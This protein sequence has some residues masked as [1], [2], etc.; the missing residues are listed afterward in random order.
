MRQKARYLVRNARLSL[1]G[2]PRHSPSHARVN[3]HKP[4]LYIPVS[5]HPLVADKRRLKRPRSTPQVVGKAYRCDTRRR[6]EML[7]LPSVGVCE[8]RN[9]I[10]TMIHHWM[11]VL[12]VSRR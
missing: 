1:L 7:T 9:R 6:Y 5:Y 2:D 11:L 12:H 10:T 8:R 3:L 4:F